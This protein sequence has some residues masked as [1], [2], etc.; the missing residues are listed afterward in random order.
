MKIGRI[1][2]IAMVAVLA[3][4]AVQDASA[5][6]TGYQFSTWGSGTTSVY[7]YVNFAPGT[8]TT[9]GPTGVLGRFWGQGIRGTFNEGSKTTDSWFQPFDTR[10]YI[11]GFMASGELGCSTGPLICL[12]QSTTT[13]GKGSSFAAGIVPFNGASGVIWDYSTIGL[14]W[15]M[16]L[17]P[18]PGV[19]YVG[20]TGS[21]VTLNVT[22]PNLA[23][24]AVGSP[25]VVTGY[26]LMRSAAA[27][28]PAGVDVGR[29]ASNWTLV[30]RVAP[31]GT[32][33]GL[34]FDCAT[35][36]AGQDLFLGVQVEFDNGQFNG[37]FVGKSTQVKC[38]STQAD[39]QFR[40][41]DKTP[42]H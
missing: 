22:F 7:N 25:N 26:R 42:K 1:A 40:K 20:K 19:T 6:A 37:D 14:D 16:T 35:L 12:V 11:Q 34:T 17:I 41:I 10:W 4:A 15:N 33:N 5:C 18:S 39:P 3:A 29:A 38:N 27:G 8:S 21:V 9:Y 30:Q 31:G 32:I 23:D 28:V 2:L 13:D 36:A 24:A